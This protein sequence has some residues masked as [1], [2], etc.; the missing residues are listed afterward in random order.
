MGAGWGIS[1]LR[2]GRRRPAST[3]PGSVPFRG[4]RLDHRP[5]NS[6]DTLRPWACSATSLPTSGSDFMCFQSTG[7]VAGCA[8]EMRLFRLSLPDSLPVLLCVWNYCL[9][10]ATVKAELWKVFP[11][12]LSPSSVSSSVRWGGQQSPAQRVWVSHT[13]RSLA[14]QGPNSVPGRMTG[15]CI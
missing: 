6:K 11:R 15:V 10:G 2:Q 14:S 5:E 8:R 4:W 9:R 7:Q 1:C 12:N 3:G 13:V